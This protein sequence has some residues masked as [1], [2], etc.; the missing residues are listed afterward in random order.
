MLCA[1]N[2]GEARYPDFFVLTFSV[3]ICTRS[4]IWFLHPTVLH[5]TAGVVG[6][7]QQQVMYDNRWGATVHACVYINTVH[8]DVT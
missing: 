4:L 6:S 2:A 1:V 3:T 7:V 5:T 8:K